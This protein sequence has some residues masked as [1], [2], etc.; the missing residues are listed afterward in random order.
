[1]RFPIT[2]FGIESKGSDT[3]GLGHMAH[4]KAFIM[5]LRN[6]SKKNI[7]K[8]VPTSEPTR[9]RALKALETSPCSETASTSVRTS[10]VTKVVCTRRRKKRSSA[11]K[12]H[13]VNKQVTELRKSE[14]MANTKGR[15][16]KRSVSDSDHGDDGPV[17]KSRKVIKR[18]P[19]SDDWYDQ[20][21]T[22]YSDLKK[23]TPGSEFDDR[24]ST[25]RHKTQKKFPDS[26]GFDVDNLSQHPIGRGRSYTHDL[27]TSDHNNVPFESRGQLSSSR[28]ISEKNSAVKVFRLSNDYDAAETTHKPA[29]KRKSN[30]QHSSAVDQ[31][32]STLPTHTPKLRD[33]TNLLSAQKWYELDRIPANVRKVCRN[34]PML[35]PSE[36]CWVSGKSPYAALHL[37]ADAVLN[38]SPEE[39][40]IED[41]GTG[42]AKK[43]AIKEVITQ[44]FDPPPEGPLIAHNV[45]TVEAKRFD[46]EA[47]SKK[48]TPP[49]KEHIY[50]AMNVTPAN[51]VVDIHVDQ[52]TNGLSVGVGK[53]EDPW[54]IK[55]H[56]VWFF[57]PPTEHNL[58]T[59][60]EL[61]QSKELRLLRSSELQHGIITAFGIHHG[62]FIPAGWLHA[63]VTTRSGFLGGINVHSPD[64]ILMASKIKS[65]D[66]RLTPYEVSQHLYNFQDAIEV[67]LD[68]SITEPQPA[69]DAAIQ[70]W[71]EVEAALRGIKINM[72]H[73]RSQC[74]KILDAWSTVLE[75]HP[76]LDDR[77]CG[78]WEGRKQRCEGCCSCRNK[79]K[80]F[81]KHFWMEHL[82]FLQSSKY[83]VPSFVQHRR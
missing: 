24:L 5:T 9:T 82:A 80:R 32:L 42:A 56:K 54:Q 47:I 51:T 61:K 66:L 18:S 40:V 68:P 65:M 69:L 15:G 2:G 74:S 76:E 37:V 81:R 57:W 55:V 3:A 59:Y 70:G 14:N 63:T 29:R 67:A 45:P 62:I 17:I 28:Y 16:I 12:H 26:D 13:A 34:V 49:S 19:S 71:F 31:I 44:L 72:A 53:D 52:G 39:Y 6:V 83:E 46:V 43:K 33:I 25:K 22:Y 27:K 75:Q 20:T 58:A 23:R 48:I 36:K 77:C 38:L 35:I 10:E 21:N 73:N 79:K 60:E 78:C 50:S 30:V 7:P 41:N 64:T 11:I 4:S 8:N 1:M